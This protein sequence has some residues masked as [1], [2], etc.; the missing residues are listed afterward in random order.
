MRYDCVQYP[1]FGARQRLQ[2]KEA[3]SGSNLQLARVLAMPLLVGEICVVKNMWIIK[4]LSF[5]IA[6]LKGL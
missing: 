3:I 6:N 1:K 2:H 4:K 5:Y